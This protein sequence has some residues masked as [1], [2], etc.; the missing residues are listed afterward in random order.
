MR[1]S[2]IVTFAAAAGSSVSSHC[3]KR[4]SLFRQYSRAARSSKDNGNIIVT[5]YL[6]PLRWAR[7]GFE[8]WVRQRTGYDHAMQD[9]A[10]MAERDSRFR[11]VL[12]GTSALAIST[13]VAYFSVFFWAYLSHLMH[14]LQPDAQKPGLFFGLFGL[15]SLVTSFTV[16]SVLGLLGAGIFVNSPTRQ[17]YPAVAVIIGFLT[18]GFASVMYMIAGLANFN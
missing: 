1:V 14:L 9:R 15:L 4:L 16:A 10:V 18:G 3:A 6:D 13:A 7:G 11:A 17:A 5:I 8:L 2:A 12:A